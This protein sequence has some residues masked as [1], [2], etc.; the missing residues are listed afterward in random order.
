MA[1]RIEELERITGLLL[2]TPLEIAIAEE[3]AAKTS[4]AKTVKGG[5][6]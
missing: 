6:K 1:A 3:D 2:P 5:N 4:K